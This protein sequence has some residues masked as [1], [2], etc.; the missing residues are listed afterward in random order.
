MRRK[1]ELIN[2]IR[3]MEKV[4]I[5]RTNFVDLTETSGQGYICEMSIAEVDVVQL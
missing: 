3:A 4:P 1:A 5:I 2:Q